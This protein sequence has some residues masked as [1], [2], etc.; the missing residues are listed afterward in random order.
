M[1]LATLVAVAFISAPL[2]STSTLAEAPSTADP[3]RSWKD[4]AAK[5][6][7]LEFVNATV[8][9]SSPDYVPPEDQIATFDQD[10]TT[11]VSHPLCGQALFASFLWDYRGAR[12]SYF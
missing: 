7:I 6:A 10:G 3:L 9:H 1:L 8:D 4:G 12:L 11:W 2:I 5:Q